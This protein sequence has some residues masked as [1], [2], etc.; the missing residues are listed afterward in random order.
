MSEARIS[1][2][3][4]AESPQPEHEE[5]KLAEPDVGDLSKRDYPAI[6]SRAAK[7]SLRDHI[8]NLAAALAYYAHPA[9]P[10]MLLVAVGVF[11]LVADE[12]AITTIVE[13]LQGVVPPGSPH[14]D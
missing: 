12:D 3:R 9:I 4:E 7:K 5:Q 11:T 6:V 14:A 1:T 10:A 13:K 8:T 2:N